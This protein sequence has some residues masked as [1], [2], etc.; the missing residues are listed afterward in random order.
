MAPEKPLVNH[1]P[2][3]AKERLRLQQKRKEGQVK[4]HEWSLA[5]LER[6]IA[7]TR[8]PVARTGLQT[9]RAILHRQWKVE[10][11]ELDELD[12]KERDIR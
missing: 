4:A 11:S 7:R 9:F 10:L 6:L 8:N 1:G 3:E 2:V 12:R 5:S